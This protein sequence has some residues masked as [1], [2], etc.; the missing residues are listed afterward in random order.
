VQSIHQTQQEIFA[1]SQ[2][3]KVKNIYFH[4][5]ITLSKAIQLLRRSLTFHHNTPRRDLP[6]RRRTSSTTSDAPELHQPP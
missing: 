4:K 5:F 6:L 2:N 3:C 1:A